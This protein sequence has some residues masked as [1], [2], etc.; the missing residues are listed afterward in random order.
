MIWFSFNVDAPLSKSPQYQA[1]HL[2]TLTA[3]AAAALVD[4]LDLF[5]EE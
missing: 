3:N 5:K 4:R 2:L 1:R